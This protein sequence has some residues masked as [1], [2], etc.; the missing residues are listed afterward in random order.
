M[1]IGRDA[2]YFGKLIKGRL[3]VICPCE[4]GCEGG[5]SISAL[6]FTGTFCVET[7]FFSG[8]LMVFF[9]VTGFFEVVFLLRGGFSP[10]REVDV[11]TELVF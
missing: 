3:C 7:D 9:E 2:S 11:D 6:G 1:K 5:F 4:S 8:F 10:C